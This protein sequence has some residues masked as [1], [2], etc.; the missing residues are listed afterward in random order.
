MRLTILVIIL[1]VCFS[2]VGSVGMRDV[3]VLKDGSLV[4]GKATDNKSTES[5]TIETE[6]G[7]IR[8]YNY[9]EIRSLNNIPVISQDKPD[10][11]NIARVSVGAGS[12]KPSYGIS[13][14]YGYQLTG[15][16]SLAGGFG[17]ERYSK[18]NVISF[19]IDAR[20]YLIQ[21]KTAPYLLMDVGYTYGLASTNYRRNT[22]GFLLMIGLGLRAQ[23]NEKRAWFLDCGYKRRIADN[24]HGQGVGSI[25]MS[26]GLS[27]N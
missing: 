18:N 14:I 4:H 7:E 3:I 12:A 15:F 11:L 2:S 6:D 16:S 5:I 19:F 24:S 9:R 20:F 26:I 13:Y 10:I 8:S 1:L 27:F 22:E 17:L 21:Q 23:T 25:E